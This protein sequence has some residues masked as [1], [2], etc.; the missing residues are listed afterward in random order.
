M[1]AER[2]SSASRSVGH[3]ALHGE[4]GVLL[5]TEVV[6]RE[7]MR[8]DV[9]ATPAAPVRSRRMSSMT[10]VPPQEAFVDTKL[11][12]EGVARRRGAV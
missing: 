2:T 10:D 3:A 5:R 4:Q 8:E 7:V 12:G 11:S 6:G 9:L 1:D